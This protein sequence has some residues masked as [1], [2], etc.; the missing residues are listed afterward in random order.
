MKARK[1]LFNTVTA[2]ILYM[3][4]G[5]LNG[6]NVDPFSNAGVLNSAI[7]TTVATNIET[8]HPY[9]D[10]EDKSWDIDAPSS[11]TSITIFFERFE[12]EQG[13]DLVYIYGNDDQE[14]VFSLSGNH[15]GENFTVEGNH[16]RIRF[17]S[18]WLFTSWGFKVSQYTFE[19]DDTPDHPTDH[20]PYC[21]A[22]GSKSEGWYWGDTGQLIRFEKCADL[23][24]PGCGA[25]GSRSEG[26]FSNGEEPLIV[27]DNCHSTVGIAL[28]GET[29]GP[30]INRTCYDGTYC[31]GLLDAQFPIGATGTCRNM[32]YCEKDSDCQDETNT[33][34]HIQCTGSASCDRDS[35]QCVW[36]CGTPGGNDEGPWSWTNVL[37]K[38]IESRHPYSNN[39]D[40]NWRVTRPGAEKIKVHFQKV[41]TE[42]AYDRLI[43]M[44]RDGNQVMSITGV[45]EDFWTPEVNGDSL[46]IILVTDYSIT[47]WGFRA[48]SVSAYKQLPK[49]KCNND[50]DC[51][52]GQVCNVPICFNPYAECP[53]T[54]EEPQGVATCA[55]DSDCGNNLRCK[56]VVDGQGTCRDE[57]WCSPKTMEKDCAGIPHITVPGSWTC[58][59]NECSWEV[60]FM[61]G[62]FE[63]NDKIDIPDADPEGIE[64]TI[65]VKNMV[66]CNVSVK[67]SLK[68]R[69]TYIGDLMIYV[70]DPAGRTAL[71]WN[72]AGGDTQDL[73]LDDFA[74][75]DGM[76]RDGAN[77]AWTLE[78]ADLAYY[79]KGTLE[80][81]S[82]AI[83]CK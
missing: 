51:D 41:E 15:S 52:Q 35:K 63:N 16:A 66:S 1:F 5:A 74:L 9:A 69:H 77:G 12:T 30:S 78:V 44:D 26:W 48:D 40:K 81:W 36:K 21:G 8:H 59:N 58:E 70:K 75:P 62:N 64:S 73:A 49:G 50:N 10:M 11:A 71:V 56:G 32:G 6:C 60:A 65:D 31:Q 2:A 47:K 72:R 18:D 46:N 61:S 14:P 7:T 53:G 38:D 29:C 34:V 4:T 20:R 67:L 17:T 23:D 19:T 25:I 24:E 43:V 45:K 55:E 83:A 13:Y 37:L 79:D 76:G 80:H 3:A 27:W 57:L 68:I 42:R 54:C 22:I 33:W 28:A 82:L 39:L